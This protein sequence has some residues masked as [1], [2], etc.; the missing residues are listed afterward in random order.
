MKSI[1]TKLLDQVCIVGLGFVGS[2]MATAVAL[3]K[4]NDIPL[5]NVVG[6]DLPNELGK[7]RVDSINKGRFPFVSDDENLL[8][9][10]DTVFNQGNLRATTDKSIYSSS[11]II[12]IDIH[13]DISYL[14]EEPQLDFNQFRK[15]FSEIGNRITTDT[16]I[17]VETTVPPGTCEKVV[18]PTLKL[19]LSKRQMSINDI[20]IAH[21][22]ER[23]MPGKNYLSSITDYWRVFS[24]YSDSAA[25][26]CEEFLKNIINVEKFPLTRLHSTKASEASKLLENTYR[27]VNIA[28]IDEWTKFSEEIGIDLFQI[29]E[30]IRMRPTHSNIRM[31]GLGVG[32]YCLTKDPTFTPAAARQ[33]FGISSDFPFSRL[34]V[35]INHNMPLHVVERLLKL[36]KIDIQK[37][38]ILVCGISYRQDI[39][40]SRYSPSEL[41]VKELL[42]LGASVTCHDPYID[43]WEEM[44][45]QI[46]N[47]NLP[48]FKNFDAIIFAVPHRQYAKLDIVSSASMNGL[49]LDT[50]GLFDSKQRDSLR[51]SGKRIES[52]GRGDGL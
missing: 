36:M 37:S 41:L 42:N 31:P 11:K 5:Y 34:A 10:F 17:I 45:L 15:V 24:G 38:N 7:E 43:Y 28:F 12:I 29:T 52:I 39:G 50:C 35:E 49:I 21:S 32:G 6:L 2:A 3:A 8:K 16:L 4:K 51:M 1:D 18:I 26:A 9:S 40:D 20:M 47:K 23:V 14:D 27:A 13:L 25:D 33:I 46:E 19:E 44:D 48:D 30:A 22:Y